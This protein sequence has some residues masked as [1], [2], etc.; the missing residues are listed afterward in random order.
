MLFLPLKTFPFFHDYVNDHYRTFTLSE[1]FFPKV[2]SPDTVRWSSSSMSG[3]LSNRVR[4]S[5]TWTK[6]DVKRNAP[7]TSNNDGSVLGADVN[8]C[9]NDSVLFSE[10][11]RTESHMAKHLNECKHSPDDL[12]INLLQFSTFILSLLGPNN[13]IVLNYLKAKHLFRQ[14]RAVLIFFGHNFP[15]LWANDIPFTSMECAV[16]E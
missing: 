7:F 13:S 4:Y 14:K 9:K 15:M 1:T 10:A 11:W 6:M 16:G 2:T 8:V 3:I 5:W 12:F